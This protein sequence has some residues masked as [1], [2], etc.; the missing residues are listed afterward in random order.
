M[1]F[2]LLRQANIRRDAIWDSE[3]R[4]TALFRATELSGELGEACNVIKKLEREKMGLRGSRETLEHLSEELADIIICVDLVAMHY[5][6]DLWYEV[7]QKF[8]A[9]SVKQNIHVT[10]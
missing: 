1:E 8:N 9:T 4:I 3:R 6:I 10:I 2:E 5:D 7:R